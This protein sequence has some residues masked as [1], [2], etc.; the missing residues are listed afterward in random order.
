MRRTLG[1]VLAAM[2]A[3]GFGWFSAARAADTKAS[4]PISSLNPK[5]IEIALPK[6][7]P[8]EGGAG[9]K[10]A[11]LVGGAN[12]PGPFVMLV[13]W[14]PHNMSRPHMHNIDR[15]I[16][17]IS[18][19][20]WVGTGSK[21]DPDSTVGVPAGSYVHHIANELHYDGAKDEEVTLEI[22]GIG[23]EKTTMAEGK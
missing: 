20:W 6:D 17:V 8:W 9:A 21:Y 4:P 3:A 12:K 23:P 11:Y 5:A 22:V 18:G 10:T 19:T 7:I 1:I 16:T 15:Y 14:M 13:K 2:A